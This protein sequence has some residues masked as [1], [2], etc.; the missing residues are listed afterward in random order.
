M[1]KVINCCPPHASSKNKLLVRSFTTLKISA[2]NK[3]INAIVFLC[4]R[5]FFIAFWWNQQQTKMSRNLELLNL[6]KIIFD[7]ITNLSE[8]CQNAQSIQLSKCLC[9]VSLQLNFSCKV[10]KFPWPFI[11]LHW[12]NDLM[13]FYKKQ[14][15]YHVVMFYF[16]FHLLLLLYYSTETQTKKNSLL[17]T[18]NFSNIF[19]SFKQINAD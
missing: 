8:K 3:H 2:F 18:L 5:I 19:E 7:D 16:S 1:K 12:H 11:Y 14:N 9:V 13:W 10:K 6:S 17:L 15:H 4:L